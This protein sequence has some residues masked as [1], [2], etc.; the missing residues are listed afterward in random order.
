MRSGLTTVDVI[1]LFT[2][3]DQATMTLGSARRFEI[4][5]HFVTQESDRWFDG[6]TEVVIHETW[7]D[8]L[9]AKPHRTAVGPSIAERC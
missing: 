8:R 9:D 2:P 6:N 7:Y 1:Q 4:D 3:Y 5:N